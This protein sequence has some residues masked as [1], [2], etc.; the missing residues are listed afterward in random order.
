MLML[1]QQISRRLTMLRQDPQISFLSSYFEYAYLL[2]NLRIL[3]WLN[4]Y[5]VGDPNSLAS[6]CK[7][8]NSWQR[9]HDNNIRWIERSF[10]CTIPYMLH[11]LILICFIIK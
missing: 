6:Y 5:T 9:I 7:L 4:C 8:I 11:N 2:L 3:L 10:Y 1:S